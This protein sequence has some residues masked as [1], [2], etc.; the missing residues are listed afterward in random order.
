MKKKIVAIV[1]C[2]LL[3]LTLLPTTTTVLAGSYEINLV[4]KNKG[5]SFYK[6][7]NCKGIYLEK[8]NIENEITLVNDGNGDVLDQYQTSTNQW[9]WFVSSWQ[10]MA[11]GFTPQ[12]ETL[13]R[14]EIYLFK[15]GNPPPTIQFTVSIRD[16]LYGDDLAIISNDV[17]HVTQQ[18]TWV[19]F[20]F[21]DLNIVPEQKY[22]IVSRTNS[23]DEDN[24]YCWFSDINDPYKRG[25]GW[26]SILDIFWEPLDFPPELPQCDLC[27]KTYGF[28]EPPNKPTITGPRT[29]KTGVEYGFTFAATDPDGHNL[30]YYIDWGD[31][32][33]E[34]WIGPYASGEDV[35]VSHTWHKIGLKIIKAKVKDVVDA[36][37]G[38]GTHA[39]ILPINQQ[40]SQSQ[41]SSQQSIIPL[42]FQI[43]Q[44]LM[45]SR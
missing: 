20:D 25:D 7:N 35:I 26:G 9:G 13:T 37:S 16:D 10:W 40:S 32:T 39:V 42:F 12:L 34:E 15:H 5:F 33:F 11:Q 24:V 6:N 8:S 18:G 28:N 19:E 27:F 1:V 36:E 30:K 45:N 29:G 17:S 44:R 22:Y 23:E 31:D 21:T 2:T 3:I 38:W 14:V 4:N 41:S 43:L